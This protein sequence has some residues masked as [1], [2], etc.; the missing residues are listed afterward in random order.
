LGKLKHE[1]KAL[2]KSQ[3]EL[4]SH[5]TMHAENNKYRKVIYQHVEENGALKENALKLA[6]Q[7][8]QERKE[9]GRHKD[10]IL[11]LEAKI[12]E[13]ELK[14]AALLPK[15]KE[16]EQVKEDL[17]LAR[18]MDLAHHSF[19]VEAKNELAEVK[20]NLAEAR[21]IPDRLEAEVKSLKGLN[22]R[23][24]QEVAV[25]KANAAGAGSHG[26][27]KRGGGGGGPSRGGWA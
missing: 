1:F 2:E 21:V 17:C 13:V 23:L 7:T 10:K 27:A 4:K 26:M 3:D 8:A 24:M 25:L 20:K 15:T 14:A 11:H 12:Q 22:M 16:H 9:L 18:K 19:L 6:N 5:N